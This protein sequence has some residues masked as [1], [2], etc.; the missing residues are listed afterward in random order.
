MGSNLPE[1]NS[2]QNQ[3]S[4]GDPHHRFAETPAKPTSRPGLDLQL[5]VAELLV[6]IDAQDGKLFLGDFCGAVDQ[7]KHFLE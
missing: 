6:R 2:P 4:R 1:L 3:S 7:R 5:L